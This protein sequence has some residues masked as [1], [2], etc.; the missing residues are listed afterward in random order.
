MDKYYDFLNSNEFINFSGD[1]HKLSPTEFVSVGCIFAIIIIQQIN[2]NEQN[3]LGNF[4][5]MVGQ[6]LLTSYAQA[7]VVNPNF[8]PTSITQTKQL[9]DAFFRHLK[10]DHF[11]K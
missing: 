11:T 6:I 9:Q 3:T 8:Q 2:P 7:T 1:I 10:K 4:L 5:E